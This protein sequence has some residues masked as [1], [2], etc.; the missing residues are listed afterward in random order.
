MNVSRILFVLAFAFTCLF[1]HDFCH[2]PLPSQKEPFLLYTNQE[3]LDLKRNFIK[4]FSKAQ[5]EIIISVYSFTDKD[6]IQALNKKAELGLRIYIGVDRKQH[7]SLSKKLSSKIEL[8]TRPQKGLMHEKIFLVD[9]TVYVGSSNLTTTSLRMHDNLMVGLFNPPLKR[10]LKNYLVEDTPFSTFNQE[11][12]EFYSLPSKIALMRIVA[13]IEESK[14]SLDI[15]L[16]TFT[17]PLIAKAVIQAHLRG[18]KV[19][20]LFDYLSHKGA[21]RFIVESLRE[22]NIPIFHNR[23]MQLMHHKM[24]LIDQDVL[25]IGSTNWTKS[26]FTRNQDDL[27]ILSSL[28]KSETKKIR[29]IFRHLFWE[30]K[31]IL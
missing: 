9:D 8:R 2:L 7:R 10:A 31:Q 1:V 27:L 22:A 24:A 12:L 6:V 17:H 20:V 26:A 21:S 4:A 28:K 29:K 14:K 3:R 5:D 23:G 25:V 30:S 11:G 16:F 18:V 15:A 13:L 19:R